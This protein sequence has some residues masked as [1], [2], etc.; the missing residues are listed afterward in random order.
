MKTWTIG[1]VALLALP[2]VASGQAGGALGDARR[3]GRE[4]HAAY[5]AGDLRTFA[6]KTDSA[7]QLRPTHPALVY[8]LAAAKALTGDTSGAVSLLGR[9]AD[10]G[11]TYD[12]AADTD[13]VALQGVPAFE[14]ARDR[15]AANGRPAGQAS[16]AFQLADP[17]LLA[18]SLAFDSSTGAFFVG[19]VRRRSVLRV[20][21]DGGVAPFVPPG[22]GG[23][24]AP[25]GMVADPVRRALWI[26]TSVVPESETGADSATGSE[27]REYDLD[28]GALRRILAVPDSA[29][30]AGDLALDGTGGVLVSDWR[31]GALLRASSDGLV[32]VLPPGSLGSPQGIVVSR[33]GSVAWIADYSLGLVRVDLRTRTVRSVPAP[34]TLLGS[35]ALLRAGSD[36][37]VVQNGVEPRRVLRLRLDRGGERVD[38]VRVLLAAHPEFADPTGAVVVGG[39]VYLIANGQ[40]SRFAGGRVSEPASLTPPVVLRIPIPLWQPE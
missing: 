30:A 10:W 13:F 2:S 31:G 38:S 26:A 12:P 14:A 24:A 39:A 1:C 23:M 16:A 3:L 20:N 37:I 4:A 18:E 9:L 5:R 8:N 27:V 36:L 32:E 40:W 6:I 25:L 34:T 33:D 29:M 22:A 15:L 17:E 21:R 35:D 28:T 11:L 7:L 19:S